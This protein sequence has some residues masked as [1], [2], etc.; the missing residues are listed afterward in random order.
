MIQCECWKS[1]CSHLYAG[2]FKEHFVS[3]LVTHNTAL[4]AEPIP[5][6]RLSIFWNPMTCKCA[7]MVNA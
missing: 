5:H 4:F 1:A 7:S 2:E 6:Q 3:P